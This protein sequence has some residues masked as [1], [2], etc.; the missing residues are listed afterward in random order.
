MLSTF[1]HSLPVRVISFETLSI[2]ST[3]SAPSSQA[4]M[5]NFSGVVC[6]GE[7]N[8]R[9][10]E[11]FSHTW[12]YSREVFS[13]QIMSII[14]QHELLMLIILQT[15]STTTKDQWN[16]KNNPFGPLLL[17]FFVTCPWK[18]NI[19]AFVS[20]K[21]TTCLKS[22]SLYKAPML[23]FVTDTFPLVIN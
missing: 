2:A 3:A 1:K 9:K 18:H 23:V 7:G 14:E 19:S 6:L 15:H 5:K 10:E 16:V 22:S 8:G 4:S 13:Q 12:K 21:Q 20:W 17:I 11:I